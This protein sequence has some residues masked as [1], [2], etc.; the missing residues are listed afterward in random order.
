VG[1]N[2]DSLVR[3]QSDWNQWRNATTRLADIDEV[4]WFQPMHA[5]RALLYGYV[6]CANLAA[7]ELPH[8]CDRSSAPHRLR[9]CILKRHTLPDVYRELARRADE[10]RPSTVERR[11]RRGRW[12]GTPAPGRRL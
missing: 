6:S 1:R 7:G 11:T 5:P 3:V 4:H 9:I 2:D 10:R 12:D 8:R